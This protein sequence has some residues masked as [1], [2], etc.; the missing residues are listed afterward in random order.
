MRNRTTLDPQCSTEGGDDSYSSLHTQGQTLLFTRE[1][2]L[3]QARFCLCRNDHSRRPLHR[4]LFVFLTI[5]DT[6][7]SQTPLHALRNTEWKV[8][9]D[10]TPERLGNSVEVRLT[11]SL[12]TLSNHYSN[13]RFARSLQGF[14]SSVY[15]GKP[16][17]SCPERYGRHPYASL[18]IWLKVF[19]RSQTCLSAKFT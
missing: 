11:R 16:E 10:S 15:K 6:A 19:Y 14:A 4:K 13:L 1:R 7:H 18:D 5:T 2:Q 3:S 12:R 8:D 17:Y 9:N